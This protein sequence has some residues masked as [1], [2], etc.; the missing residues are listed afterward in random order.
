MDPNFEKRI[1]DLQQAAANEYTARSL[2]NQ[3][4][5]FRPVGW[6]GEVFDVEGISPSFSRSASNGDY[7]NAVQDPTAPGTT[8]D[9]VATTTMLDTL[10]CMERAFRVRQGSRRCRATAQ[11]LGRKRG[12]GDGLGPLVQN[13]LEYVRHVLAEAKGAAGQ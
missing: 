5:W 8:G 1:R 13:Y 10:A 6:N 12:Q 7:L 9:V 11:M 2:G 4:P 3:V